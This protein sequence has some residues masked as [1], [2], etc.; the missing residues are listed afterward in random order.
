MTK[1][2]YFG[3]HVVSF[4]G[5][6]LLLLF[7]LMLELVNPMLGSGGLFLCLGY[8]FLRSKQ[9]EE[10]KFRD[11]HPDYEETHRLVGELETMARK[12]SSVDSIA[13]LIPLCKTCGRGAYLYQ[14][15]CDQLGIPAHNIED[16][17][18]RDNP[19]SEWWRQLQ[20]YPP[21][22]IFTQ[23]EFTFSIADHKAAG[24][25]YFM[26]HSNAAW[27]RGVA[28]PPQWYVAKT[29]AKIE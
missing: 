26:E 25:K 20:G 8:F 3:H 15:V 5:L 24:K 23:D 6:L 16:T 27:D 13:N 4:V 12:I 28:D 2:M 29:L 14:G 10:K 22:A 19:Y 7:A 11:H 21:T 18:P 1:K 9:L 17:P